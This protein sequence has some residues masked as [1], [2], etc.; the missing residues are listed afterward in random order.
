MTVEDPNPAEPGPEH[1][2]A[3]PPPPA[4]VSGGRR[5]LWLT[6]GGISAIAAVAALVLT[7]IGLFLQ[8]RS[9]A[10]VPAVESPGPSP[11]A[12]VLFV[13]GSSMPGMS[14]YGEIS[15]YVTGSTRDSVQGQLY[16]SGLGYPMAKF[17]GDGEVRGFLLWLDP[18]TADAALAEMTRV[19]AGLFHPVSVRTRSGVTAQAYQWIEA[20]DGYPRIETWDGS[21]EDF[22]LETPWPELAV[23]DCFQPTIEES[24]VLTIWCE[25]PHAYEVYHAAP[26][27]LGGSQ[28]RE[29]AEAECVAAF[30]GFVGIPHDESTLTTR[31]YSIGGTRRGTRPGAVRGGHSRDAAGRHPR[32]GSPLKRSGFRPCWPP[33]PAQLSS[34]ATIRCTL[35]QVRVVMSLP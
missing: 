26:L 25:A 10:S 24:S 30:A 7:G 19:E 22:G 20:T 28:A 18:Q 5:R 27:D 17:G 11:A 32:A 4:R 8:A 35:S 2:P 34:L 23:G 21:T 9:S 1:T 15:E 6:P 31:V 33:G 16:D 13:Y 3:P 12:P 29:A 14:R